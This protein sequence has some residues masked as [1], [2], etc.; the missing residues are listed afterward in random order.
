MWSV[1]YESFSD[2][3]RP[4]ALA[5]EDRRD[6]VLVAYR[7]FRGEDGWEHERYSRDDAGRVIQIERT[8]HDRLTGGEQREQFQVRYDESGLLAEIV[9]DDGRRIYQAK[10]AKLGPL[11][12]RAEEAL[13]EEI[14]EMLGALDL[15]QRDAILIGYDYASPLEPTLAVSPGLAASTSREPVDVWNPWEQERRAQLSAGLPSLRLLGDDAGPL[16]AAATDDELLRGLMV[17][18]AN[19]TQKNDRVRELGATVLPVDA[20]MEH[21]ERNARELLPR[22]QFRLFAAMFEDSST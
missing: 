6:G 11:L 13:A 8:L 9:D 7:A 12:R 18:V 16:L 1:R 3:V 4:V 2:Q 10:P 14:A 5:E 17:K 15:R 21:L 20:D 19:R 22:P